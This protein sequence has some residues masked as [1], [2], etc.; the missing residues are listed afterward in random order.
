MKRRAVEKNMNK[1]REKMGKY[2]NYLKNMPLF[3]KL[4]VFMFIVLLF[5]TPTH[6][7]QLGISFV[8]VILVIVMYLFLD[9]AKNT[10]I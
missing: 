3:I 4:Y 6:F 5:I 9:K 1:K 2:L 8:F 10:K 7:V